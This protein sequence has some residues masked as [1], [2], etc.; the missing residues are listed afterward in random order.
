MILHSKRHTFTRSSSAMLM[1]RSWKFH[2][3]YEQA[4]KGLVQCSAPQCSE[5]CGMESRKRNGGARLEEGWKEFVSFYSIVLGHFILFRYD[6]NSRFHVVIFDMSACEI[7]YPCQP[8]MVHGI[9][10]QEDAE[11]DEGQDRENP[12]STG[13]QYWD[14]YDIQ[15]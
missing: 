9:A 4:W 11:S 12:V 1:N 3:L 14:M 13:Q 8:M 15:E 10:G 5:W 6:G 2:E 7:E